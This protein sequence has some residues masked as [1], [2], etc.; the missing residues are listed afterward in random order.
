MTDD[1]VEKLSG[2][3]K[4]EEPKFLE[5]VEGELVIS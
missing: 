1:I 5:M 4:Y 2:F 3:E